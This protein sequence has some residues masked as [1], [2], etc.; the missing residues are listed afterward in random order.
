MWSSARIRPGGLF[1]LIGAFLFVFVALTACSGSG[2]SRSSRLD[3]PQGMASYYA[4]QYAGETTASGETFD[5][6]AMTAAHPSLPFE[7]VVRVTRVNGANQSV[8]VRINDRGPFK[9]D[10]IIDLSEAAARKLRMIREGVVEVRLEIVE[11]PE[12]AGGASER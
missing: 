11:W 2:S 3:N 5:P 4:D 12:G 7:T 1:V 8:V 9:D 10:R 6:D